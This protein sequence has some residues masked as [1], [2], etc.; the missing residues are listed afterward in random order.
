MPTQQQMH[1]CPP[2]LLNMNIGIDHGKVSP[3]QQ[4]IG[5]SGSKMIIPAHQIKIAKKDGASPSPDSRGF[6]TLNK[7]NLMP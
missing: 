5:P 3:T 4:I 6:F 2:N 7:Q 1:P